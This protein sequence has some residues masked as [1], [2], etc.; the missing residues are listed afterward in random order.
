[1]TFTASKLNATSDILALSLSQS[2]SPFPSHLSLALQYL[3]A[4]H[5][6]VTGTIAFIPSP[7]FINVQLISIVFPP[8]L[9]MISALVPSRLLRGFSTPSAGFSRKPVL[10]RNACQLQILSPDK[11]MYLTLHII[12]L[13]KRFNYQFHFLYR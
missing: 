2:N 4:L 11:L 12:T 1:M 9:S 13:N 6:Y 10:L 5:I 8:L 3:A 7:L